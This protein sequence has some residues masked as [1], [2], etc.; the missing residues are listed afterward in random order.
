MIEKF[1]ARY[2]WSYLGYI[3]CQATDT[4]G[5]HYEYCFHLMERGDG[6][7][8]VKTT[9]NKWALQNPANH[10]VEAN[11]MRWAYGGSSPPGFIA[12]R[13]EKKRLRVV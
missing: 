12:D 10:R 7:R 2:R 9:G 3:Y 8:R 5:V 13:V 11:V 6:K 4:G 1:L